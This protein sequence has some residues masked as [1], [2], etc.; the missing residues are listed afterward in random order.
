MG[1][2]VTLLEQLAA[3][4]RASSSK[5]ARDGLRFVQRDP[6][7]GEDYLRIPMPRAEVL[8]RALTTLGE[9]LGRFKR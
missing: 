3:A 6:G 8:D 1:V 4:S 7:T 9:M 2:F 5:P